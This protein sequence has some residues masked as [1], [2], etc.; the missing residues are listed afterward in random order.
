MEKHLHRLLVNMAWGA[1]VIVI[2]LLLFWLGNVFGGERDIPLEGLQPLSLPNQEKYEAVLRDEEIRNSLIKKKQKQRMMLRNTMKVI[3]NNQFNQWISDRL[4]LHRRA[5]DTRPLEC[6]YKKYYPISELPTVS[7]I[8]IF[9]NEARSTLLRTVWSVLDRSHRS[10]IKEIIL[11]DDH[12]SMEH[13]GYPLEQEVR[14]I[15]KD[16]CRSS[17][18]TLRAYSCQGIRCATSTRRCSCILRQ[19]LRGQWWLAWASSWPH[20]T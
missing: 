3:K 9:Y 4:S 18:R 17:S 2:A 11:V 19:P 1:A 13:L 16:T 15:P 10:L 14:Y 6:I 12:S 8:I 7:V 5:Y 20:P